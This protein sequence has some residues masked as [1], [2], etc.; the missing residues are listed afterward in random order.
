MRPNPKETM[1]LVTFTEEMRN[2]NLHCFVQ[3]IVFLSQSNNAKV[4]SLS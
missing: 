2:G 4:N 1:D 3:C